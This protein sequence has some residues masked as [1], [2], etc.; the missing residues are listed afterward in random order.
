MSYGLQITEANHDENQFFTLGGIL[1]DSIEERDAEAAQIPKFDHD[2]DSGT[3]CYMLDLLEEDGF[4]TADG[5]EISKETA[6]TLLGVADLEP[7]RESERALFGLALAFSK[8]TDSRND[9]GRQR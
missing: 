1:V 4:S 8:S 6:L 7:L 3:A 5:F 9:D 2:C